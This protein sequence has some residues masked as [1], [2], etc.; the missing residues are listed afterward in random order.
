MTQVLID[1][2]SRAA[3]I[4]LLAVGLTL[5]YSLLRFPN[6]AHVEFAVVG[7]YVAML[8]SLTLGLPLIVAVVLAVL[9]AGLAGVLMDR[10]VFARLRGTTPILMMIA[11]FGLGIAMRGVIRAIWG[12][13]PRS[14][15][16]GLQT[17]VRVL[18]ATL[19]PIQGYILLIA[20]VSMVGFYLLLNFT[21]LGIAMRATADNAGL[22]SASGIYTERVIA[23]VWF[24][25]AAFAGLAGVLIGLDTQLFPRMGFGIIIP[26]F[27]AAI[28]GGIGNPY[29]AVAGALVI[30]LAE[31]VGLA[32]DWQPLLGLFGHSGGS[33]HI[34]ASWRN[35]IPFVLLIAALLLR[36]QGLFTKRTT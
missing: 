15:E 16:L 31:N 9:I 23:M 33:A 21:R 26:V 35:G 7:A 11:S 1:T 32:I 27:S 19:T 4:S 25:G 10:A 18:D 13:A 14:Y 28:L 29:G 6:F 24:L 8:L 2:L 30:G 5:V 17:P 3:Q 34:P 20:A 22:A 36:P 12:S